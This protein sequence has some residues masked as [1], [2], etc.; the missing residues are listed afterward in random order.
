MGDLKSEFQRQ[1]T[2]LDEEIT[3]AVATN[4]QSKRE[5]S[6]TVIDGLTFINERIMTLANDIRQLKD[7]LN[8]YEGANDAVSADAIEPDMFIPP[9][10]VILPVTTMLPSDT[11]P[12]FILNSFICYVC[13]IFPNKIKSTFIFIF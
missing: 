7:E 8:V 11:K 4:T 2:T 13:F 9:V 1:I 10:A 3:A 5:F 6:T 12:F